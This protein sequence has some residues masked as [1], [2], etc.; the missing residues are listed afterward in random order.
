MAQMNYGCYGL[1]LATYTS[2]SVFG[3]AEGQ[4]S[5]W[6]YRTIHSLLGYFLRMRFILPLL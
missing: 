1:L 6:K 3:M 2:L 4:V 5:Y